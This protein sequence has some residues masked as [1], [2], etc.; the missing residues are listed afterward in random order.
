MLENILQF[1]LSHPLYFFLIIAWSTIW[2]GV[3]LWY[4]A[5]RRDTGWFIAIFLL[6]TLGIL[7]IVYLFVFTRLINKNK[8]LEK[9]ARKEKE[10]V[11]NEKSGGEKPKEEAL[12]AEEINEAEKTELVKEPEEK[13]EKQSSSD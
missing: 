7:E 4:S 11:K 13:T 12:K 3:A 9:L 5:Q 8:Q 6:N 2:K 1:L 10:E